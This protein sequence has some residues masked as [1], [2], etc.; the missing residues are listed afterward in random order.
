MMTQRHDEP[1]TPGP[2]GPGAVLDRSAVDLREHDL[3]EHGLRVTAPRLA[4]LAAIAEDPHADA[5]TIATAV[6]KRLGAVS[7]QAVYDVL[8]AL[9]AAGLVRRISLDER[10]ARFELARHDN[11]HHLVCRRCGRIH[12]VACVL[13][14]APCLDPEAPRGFVVEQADVIYRGLCA[15]CA[16]PEPAAAP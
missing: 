13:G 7:R 14:A 1:G 2:E 9:T 3:R 12:D 15:D 4:A 6:R 5:D 11:H 10:R 16:A 8:H